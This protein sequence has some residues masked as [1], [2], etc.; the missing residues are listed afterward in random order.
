MNRAEIADIKARF[1]RGETLTH[2][3][4]MALIWAVDLAPSVPEVL[5]YAAEGA[6]EFDQR[7]G[8]AA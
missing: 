5:T 2:S 1:F 3:D 4:I 7:I 6:A 8:G